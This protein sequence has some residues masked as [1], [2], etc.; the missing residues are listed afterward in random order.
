MDHVIQTCLSL[1]NEGE[2]SLCVPQMSPVLPTVTFTSKGHLLSVL[3]EVIP[4]SGACG[5][6]GKQGGLYKQKG[7]REEGP[8]T[9]D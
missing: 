7:G 3:C 8:R 6:Q 4:V 1:N 5:R 9:P 2:E